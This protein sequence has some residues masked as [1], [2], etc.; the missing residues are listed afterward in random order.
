MPV[1]NI[2][3]V[4]VRFSTFGASRG[5]GQRS[6]TSI[7]SPSSIVSPRRLK[8]RPRVTSPTG[9]VIGP[10][11]SVTSAPRARPSVVSI[12]T[13]RTRSSPRCCCTSQTSTCPLF[14]TVI[15]WLISGSSSGKTASM[16]TP[17]ISSMRPVFCLL[18]V[19]AIGLRSHQRFGAG[20][21]FHD[22][23]GDLRLAGTVHLEREVLDD[24]AGVLRGVAHGGHARAQL[25]GGRLEQCPVERDLD[26][27]GDEALEDLLGPGLVL[28]ERVAA[29]VLLVL[30]P[31]RLEDRRLL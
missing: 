24:L 14:S 18:S 30:V 16:T 11:V 25:G 29:G 31:L 20:D 28:D 2:S 13:A 23:L 10:P 15:A 3:V 6:L 1:S 4:G 12:A 17:W 21:N 26:V 19:A 22:L 5:I 8:M 27:V 7:A 9:T